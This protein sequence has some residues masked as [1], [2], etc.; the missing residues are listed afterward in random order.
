MF[1]DALVNNMKLT[2]LN[3]GR[4]H[5]I[6]AVYWL[7]ILEL[8]CD[9]SNI[10]GVIN[11]NHIIHVDYHTRDDIRADDCN[12]L[13]LSLNLNRDVGE[14]SLVAR[15]KILWSHARGDLN[16]GEDPS[17]ANGVMPHILT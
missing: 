12:L 8:V 6:T 17:V 2:D 5:V 14:K 15:H 1:E 9:G 16:I 7:A 11:S 13:C 4:N 10:D 3:L